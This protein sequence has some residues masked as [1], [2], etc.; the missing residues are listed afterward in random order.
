M[1]YRDRLYRKCYHRLF[2]HFII[3]N[4]V[5]QVARNFQPNLQTS[6]VNHL[7]PK[8][9]LAHVMSPELFPFAG[10][11]HKIRLKALGIAK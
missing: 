2:F 10:E 3:L 4:L 7:F 6:P 5:I 9:N 8:P 1:H 11:G